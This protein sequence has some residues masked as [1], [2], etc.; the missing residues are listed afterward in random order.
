LDR[1]ADTSLIIPAE[2]PSTECR[3]L[4]TIVEYA[5]RHLSTADEFDPTMRRLA[6]FILDIGPH[7]GPATASN[8]VSGWVAWRDQ[9]H[10]L[11]RRVLAWA[12]DTGDEDVAYQTLYDFRWWLYVSGR[13]TEHC[14]WA[15]AVLDLLEE[16]ATP[17]RLELL[18]DAASAE[19]DGGDVQRSGELLA[20]LSHE[21]EALGEPRYVADARYLAAQAAYRAGELSRF[22][23]LNQEAAELYRSVGH[24]YYLN[25]ACRLIGVHLI[26]GR[27]NDAERVLEEIPVN[28]SQLEHPI[29]ADFVSA[30]THG[31]SALVALHRGD[32]ETVE[33]ILEGARHLLELGSENRSTY[34]AI[35]GYVALASG[36]LDGARSHAEEAAVHAKE[37]G[38]LDTLI[39]VRS[40]QAMVEIGAGNSHAAAA[41]VDA[42]LDYAQRYGALIETAETVSLAADLALAAGSAAEAARL[43][44][45][46]ATARHRLPVVLPHWRQER[47]NRTLQ[48]LR[49]T[50]GDEFETI[51]AEG[52]EITLEDAVARARTLVSFALEQSGEE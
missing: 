15:T 31:F 25:A 4:E 52:T 8:D 38:S 17:R 26:T 39:Y 20:Q 36:D 41:H 40:L 18:S 50:F 32:H 11:F 12:I 27:Y 2:P 34:T 51:W 43:H 13:E 47:F 6:T 28:H 37:S 23:D 45:A 22:L 30:L 21:A 42:T 5:H 10:N 44:A 29:S 33:G 14:R 9:H 19:A 24:S 49:A 1:L 35:L 16:E 7:H 46:A 48:E 3:M